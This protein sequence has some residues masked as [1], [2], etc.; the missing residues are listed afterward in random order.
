MS[1]VKCTIPLSTQFN[2][3]V[4]V[5]ESL[6]YF[7]SLLGQVPRNEVTS[8]HLATLELVAD[9]GGLTSRQLC[10]L[11]RALRS[12]SWP[13]QLARR[14]LYS[15][16]P[17]DLVPGLELAALCLWALGA[18]T[19]SREC[20]VLPALRLTCLCLQYDCVDD[21]RPVSAL[22]EMFIKLLCKEKV[23]VVAAELLCLLTVTS[24]VRRWR[25][26]AVMAAQERLGSQPALDSLIFKYRQLRPDL[27][28]HY[29]APPGRAVREGKSAIHRRFHRV[30]EHRVDASRASLETIWARG[31]GRGGE[32]VRKGAR[33]TLVPGP[34]ALAVQ[35]GLQSQR[36]LLPLA[37]CS[38]LQEVAENQDRI[39][40]PA[41]IL[42]LLGC[43]VG[44]NV[45]VTEPALVERLSLTL[46][47]TLRN[48]FL[49][50]E[51]RTEAAA[52]EAR[53]RRRRSQLLQLLVELQ[54]AVQ[55]GLPVV[56]R[57]LTEYLAVWDGQQHFTVVLKLISQ[58]QIT[59]F[60]EL[61]DCLL[62]PVMAHYQAYSVIQQ[63]VVLSYLGE[64]LRS[65][66]V[67]E[68][69]RF[70]TVDQ[71]ESESI[72]PINS[73][74]CENSV[75][76]ILELS[77]HLGELATLSLAR[78]QEQEE[79]TDLLVSRVF[80]MYKINQKC[81]MEQKVPVRLEVPK[82]YFYASLFSYNASLIDQ[83][84]QL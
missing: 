50:S 49:A 57:F 79:D 66:A 41:Q 44:V 76:S 26:E 15:L 11:L 47:H 58:V 38:S 63:T 61:Y 81:M 34:G 9:N 29:T 32:V 43:R 25:V 67:T 60:K 1:C 28:P 13:A 42:A 70:N 69:K 2:S 36:S 83:V 6:D 82:H 35:S 71:G 59:D 55:Q 53:R 30:W 68:H 7:S 12:S 20:V 21:R 31:Q 54:E 48:E 22:Y 78:A 3:P 77:R 80:D 27:V 64:L 37:Q 14:L 40:L 33:E 62:E 84:R 73:K 8:R 46:Y 52:G 4:Q 72:F 39:Q 18:A 74:H 24:D 5:V 65:W 16:V 23:G 17:G 10:L 56:G 75:Q 19:L 51:T 45:L